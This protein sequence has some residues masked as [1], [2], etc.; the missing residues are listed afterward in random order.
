MRLTLRTL[1][2]HMDDVLEPND[3]A[4]VGQK[5]EESEFAKTLMQRIRDVTSRLRLARLRSLAKV[6]PPTRIPWPSI[7][8]TP[9][10]TNGFRNLKR[11]AS[12]PM[13]I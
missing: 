1:L 10:T 13:S 11:S 2:A 12:N 9:C 6:S 8:T 7:L 3:R 5:I 4:E